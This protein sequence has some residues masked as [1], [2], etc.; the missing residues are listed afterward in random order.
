LI[1]IN[2]CRAARRY[3]LLLYPSGQP[4]MSVVALYEVAGTDRTGRFS[5][6]ALR[7]IRLTAFD[8]ATPRRWPRSRVDA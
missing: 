3:G 5:I 8:F 7:R 2:I 4:F 6:A 1:S